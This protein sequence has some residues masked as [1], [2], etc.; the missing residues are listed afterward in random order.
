MQHPARQGREGAV[1]HRR[2]AEPRDRGR[3]RR[4]RRGAAGGR[5]GSGFGITLGPLGA[6]MARRLQVPPGTRG[7]LITDVEPA[8][9]AARA[10][11]RPGDVILKVNGQ[12]VDLG[13][14]GQPGAARRSA[15]AA[16]RACCSGVPARSSSPSSRRSSR[17]DRRRRRRMPGRGLPRAHRLNASGSGGRSRPPSTWTWRSTRRGLVTTPVRPSVP[18]ARAISLP[19]SISGRCSARCSAE[20][21]AGHGGAPARAARRAAG[22]TRPGR[23][24]R[25]QR[26]AVARRARRARAPAPGALR[27]RRAHAGRAQRGRPRGAARRRWRARRP[28]RGLAAPTCRASIHRHPL[29]QRTAR[30]VSRARRPDD[31]AGPGRGLR[32]PRRR[33][34]DRAPRAAL[35]AGA[36]RVS[37]RGRRRRSSRACAARSTWPPSTGSATPRAA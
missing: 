35:D 15:R 18:A 25:R 2:G 12:A 8:S 17:F 14:R 6:D 5:R 33:P 36:R 21:F 27:G 22:R 10:G 26:P 1:G 19:A 13:G 9:T 3:R 24:G 28:P 34:A 7:V 23:S 32:R 11:V 4:Q 29:R 16:R 20:A 30:R 31:A 37:R